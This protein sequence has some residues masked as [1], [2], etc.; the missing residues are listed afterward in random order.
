MEVAIGGLTGVIFA[1]ARVVM[2]FCTLLIGSWLGLECLLTKRMDQRRIMTG[3][4][5]LIDNEKRYFPVM[6][7]RFYGRERCRE[8]SIHDSLLTDFLSSKHQSYRVKAH[9]RLRLEM[10]LMGGL[11]IAI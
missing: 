7:Q 2:V 3:K 1:W 10:R 5:I 11:V 4:R 8:A 6:D 9:S